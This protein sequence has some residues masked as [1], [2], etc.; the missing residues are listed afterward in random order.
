MDGKTFLL[1]MSVL[2]I[3]NTG[4]Q[5]KPQPEAAAQEKIK[6]AGQRF[7]VVDQK[8]SELFDQIEAPS[9]DQQFRTQLIC[10]DY[11]TLY[12]QQYMP[13]LLA[14]SPE[15]FSKDSLLS[16]FEFVQKDLTERY[17]IEC[18]ENEP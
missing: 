12:K 18:T 17:G 4:C 16:D 14:L 5:D 15:Q 9:T 3:F 1:V 8:L 7:D 11:P 2:L 13:A 6:Q 10:K